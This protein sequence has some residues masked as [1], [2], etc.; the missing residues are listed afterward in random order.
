[1]KDLVYE[2]GRDILTSE[3]FIRETAFRHHGAKS[4]FCHSVCVAYESV[5]LALKSKKKVD[6]RSLV[7]GALLHD[8]YLYDWHESDKS[9]KWHGYIHAKRALENAEKDFGLNDI[10]RDIIFKHMFPLNIRFPRYR[11][12]FIVSMADKKC[13]LRDFGK[14]EKC[15]NK[16]ADGEKL[17]RRFTDIVFDLDGTLVDTSDAIIKT[18]RQTLIDYGY[19]FTEEYL[20]GIVNGVSIERSLSILH[21]KDDG[22]FADKWLENHGK[23]IGE[24][25]YFKDALPLLKYLRDTGYRLGIVTSRPKSEYYAY[26]AGLNVEK[27]VDRVVLADETEKHKPDPEPLEKYAE[28]AGVRT[29]NCLYVG[30]M[31]TDIACAVAAKAGSCFI[32]RGKAKPLPQADYNVKNLKEIKKILK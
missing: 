19:D 2:Y 16:L 10:E 17:S 15:K 30:D 5:R 22:N 4:C 13:S 14:T 21:V 9:H 1:M 12:T 31:P 25:K 18:W 32:R 3:K 7:R 26:L 24:A 23:F 20:T 6:M 11:E 8:Y 28:L 29:E 27:Y